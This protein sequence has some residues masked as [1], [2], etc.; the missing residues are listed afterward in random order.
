MSAWE[1]IMA[2]LFNPK[3][4]DPEAVETRIVA[5]ELSQ[6]IGQRADEL[7]NHLKTYQRARDPFAALMADLYNRD[8]LEKIY[9]GP[10]P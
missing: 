1:R 3:G 5:R 6:R 7:N 10:R 8:Q 9:R 2:W 4:R